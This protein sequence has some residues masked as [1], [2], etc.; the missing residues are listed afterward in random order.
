[1]GFWSG[2]GKVVKG[3]GK[4]ALSILGGPVGAAISGVGGALG[5]GAG[6]SQEGRYNKAALMAQLNAANNTAQLNAANFN[7]AAPSALTSQ[8]ARGDV[9]SS[10]QNAPLLGDPR[11]DKFSGGGLRPS[12]FGAASR[13]AGGELS[14]QAM[15]KLLKGEQLS[16]QMTTLQP[17]GM[18]EKIGGAAGLAGGITGA[19]GESGVLGSLGK[20][21]G[22]NLTGSE[23]IGPPAPAGY[24]S[25]G[26]GYSAGA[27]GSPDPNALPVS[28]GPELGQALPWDPKY[29]NIED[30]MARIK[31]KMDAAKGIK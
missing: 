31:A 6:A 9:L 26:Y 10:M 5:K 22:P 21:S 3:I 4:G 19:L 8:V 14:R 24:Q 2:L 7:L 25:G 16:P 18:M 17:G 27:G 29:G 15:Q 12:A 13:Q 23:F 28:Q 11:I 30:A 1:M 20:L